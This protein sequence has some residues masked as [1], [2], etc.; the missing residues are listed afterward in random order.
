LR[1]K[2]SLRSARHT[3]GALARTPVRSASR[4][5]Y[6]ASVKAFASA[7][8]ARG[9]AK[10][11]PSSRGAGPPRGGLA[12]RR[13][14]LRACC[15]QRDSVVSPTSSRVAIRARLSRPR[16]QARS[17]RCLES[18]EQ[19]RGIYAPPHRNPFNTSSG[20]ALPTGPKTALAARKP[21]RPA[22]AT[23]CGTRLLARDRAPRAG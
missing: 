2:P 23:T 16:S 15:C 20:P 18:V 19:G 13:P 21:A 12:S 14:S 7:A 10:A 8:K 1:T 9:A 11:A 17:T 6:P 5:A 3:V 4:S 22:A